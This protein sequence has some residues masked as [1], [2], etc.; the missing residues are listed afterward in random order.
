MT[1][2]PEIH[3]SETSEDPENRKARPVWMMRTADARR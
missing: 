1:Y 2:I 3:G